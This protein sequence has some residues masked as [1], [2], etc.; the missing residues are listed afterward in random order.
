MFY[1]RVNL[2]ELQEQNIVKFIQISFVRWNCSEIFRK[3]IGKQLPKQFLFSELVVVQQTCNHL[4]KKKSRRGFFLF[5]MKYSRAAALHNICEPLFE[6]K[7]SNNIQR[8]KHYPQSVIWTT[9]QFVVIVV[10]KSKC[11]HQTETFKIKLR[12]RTECFY[13]R[14]RATNLS[15]IYPAMSLLYINKVV[16]TPR[17]FMK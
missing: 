5:F 14:L 15:S 10:M 12:I 17:R 2:P 6:V 9:S 7:D 3:F 1:F 8:D 11:N 16:C 4:F 13:P